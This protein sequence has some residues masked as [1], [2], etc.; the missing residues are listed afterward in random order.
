MKTDNSRLPFAGARTFLSFNPAISLSSALTSRLA[1]LRIH[2]LNDKVN[3]VARSAELTVR[4][5]SGKF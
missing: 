1:G 2:Q 5:G 4:A 3:D